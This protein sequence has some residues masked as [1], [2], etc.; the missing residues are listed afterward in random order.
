MIAVVDHESDS[1]IEVGATAAAGLP[2]LLVHDH[3][4]SALSEARRSR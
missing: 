3:V 4:M 2:R 1:G